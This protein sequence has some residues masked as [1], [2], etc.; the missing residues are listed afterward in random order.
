MPRQPAKPEE[1]I[2]CCRC[3]KNKKET[4]FYKVSSSPLWT[5]TKNRAPFCKDCIEQIYRDYSVQYGGRAAIIAVA[6]LLDYPF[7]PD[8]YETLCEKYGA[9]S[10]GN[11]IRSMNAIQYKSKTFVM[12]IANGDLGKDDDDIQDEREAKWSKGDKVNMKAVISMMGYDPF[13]DLGLT[14]AERKY[15]FNIMAGYCSIPNIEED[16]HKLESAVQITLSRLQC[17]QIDNMLFKESSQKS[18]NIKNI[19]TLSATK[20]T[21]VSSINQIAKENGLS[22]SSGSST[23]S[24]STL[25]KKMKEL[26]ADD[27]KAIQVNTFDINTCDAMRKIADL[28]NQSIMEQLSFE[29]SDYMEMVKEQREMIEALREERDALKEENRNLKNKQNYESE[30]V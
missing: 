13:E 12:S 28:S 6:A 9:C 27:F 20:R 4:E 17:K 10:L 2:A 18:P 23:L 21:L 7:A 14:D 30:A 19:D 25:T 8:V 15:C 24:A 5:A 11:Y 26:A 3:G 1:R 16:G 22:D 29:N